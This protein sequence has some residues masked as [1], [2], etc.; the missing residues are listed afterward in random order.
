MIVDGQLEPGAKISE[1]DLCLLF[2]ISRTPLREALK[3]LAAEGMIELLP[4]R[5]ARVV[6]ISDEELHE[7]FP[8]IA[9]LEALAGELAC[10]TISPEQLAN[11]Q[12]LHVAMIASYERAERLEY[13]RLN[14]LIHFAIFEAAQ[15]TSLTT[16]YGNL[17]LK[18]RNIRHTV[19]QRPQDWRQAV[20]DHENI[21][22]A[23]A[24][25]DKIRLSE[26]MRRHVMNTAE[27]VRHSVKDLGE[28]VVSDI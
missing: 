15:N 7:L 3:A 2:D 24:A 5:G 11:I 1:R 21:I 6:M 26:V 20:D 13:S 18:I 16:L 27:M 19:R 8:I 14:R 12:A 10:E 22:A 28:V 9:S 23:L 4:Q 17:E 25:R